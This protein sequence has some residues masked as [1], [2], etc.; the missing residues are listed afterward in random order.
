MTEKII[1]KYPFKVDSIYCGDN[2]HVL[3][4]QNFPSESVDLIYMDPPFFTNKRYE[5]IFGDEAEIRAFDD[6]WSGGKDGVRSIYID[7][8]RPRIKKMKRIL[9]STGS[10]YLHCDWHASH[11]LKVLC[12]GI[13][14][15][16]NFQNEIVWCYAGGG[17][18]KRAFARKHDILLF[19]SKSQNKKRVFNI[20]RL[21]YGEMGSGKKWLR[22]DGSKP[23][24]EGKH[25]E[26]WWI[27]IKPILP[28]HGAMFG[29]KAEHLGYPTQ[30]PEALLERIIKASSNEG[31]IVLDPFCGC[32]TTIAVAEKL[33]RRYIGIDH[34]PTACRVMAKRIGYPEHKII[35]LPHTIKELRELP[36]FEFQIWVCRQMGGRSNP[37]K[38]ADGGIDGW[39]SYTFFKGEV[40]IQVKRSDSVGSP[41]VKLFKTNIEEVDMNEGYVVAFS[42]S[43]GAIEI[44]SHIKNKYGIDIKLITV[45]ELL[46]LNNNK[47]EV[48]KI[49]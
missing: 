32:G 11:Y 6:R 15:R 49:E 20:Q 48:K 34:S 47:K 42:F 26:D 3:D 9:K 44:A 25:M 39:A 1:K 23:L 7:Y 5:I 41:V 30:K 43:K 8:M 45:K 46:D 2:F 19:Y 28:L 18:P 36:P 13:F 4:V 17:V 33:N 31:D 35:G 24:K 22:A 14:G 12:D 29:D 40:P 37:K 16:N 21:P 10:F 38:V 27:D